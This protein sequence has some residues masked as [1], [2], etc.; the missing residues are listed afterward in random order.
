M[1]CV[2]GYDK[3]MLCS[4]LGSLQTCRGTRGTVGQSPA[5]MSFLH[6]LIGSTPVKCG[7]Q[8]H[9]ASLLSSCRMLSV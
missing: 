6:F 5:H 3:L 1:L 4:P 9:I 7:W 2:G 8:V